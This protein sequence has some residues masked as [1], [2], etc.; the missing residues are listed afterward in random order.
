M[1]ILVQP[2]FATLHFLARHQHLDLLGSSSISFG[3][4]NY[5]R[6]ADIEA[7]LLGTNSMHVGNGANGADAGPELA[8]P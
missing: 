6:V 1:L 8:K 4:R 3:E 7:P 5:S 2:T